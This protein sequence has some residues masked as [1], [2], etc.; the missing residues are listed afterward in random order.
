MANS[1]N[2]TP[3]VIKK[4]HR[5]LLHQ[6]LGIPQGSKIPLSKLM[7][8]KKSSSPQIKKEANFAVNF[9]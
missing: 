7:A 1:N 9:R 2:Y 3:P 5:G 6:H 4:S 8:A